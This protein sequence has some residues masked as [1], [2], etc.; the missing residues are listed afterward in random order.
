LMIR[1]IIHFK[2]LKFFL[3]PGITLLLLSFL[4]LIYRLIRFADVS[5]LSIILFVGGLQIIFIGI[6]ADLIV[7]HRKT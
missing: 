7:K 4:H 2:P 6:I 5:D 3:F 1:V